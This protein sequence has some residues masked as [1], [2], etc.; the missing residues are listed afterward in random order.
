MGNGLKVFGHNFTNLSDHFVDE[1]QSL[2]R[3]KAIYCDQWIQ[4]LD[5]F[6]HVRIPF[7][8]EDIAEYVRSMKAFDLFLG[9]KYHWARDVEGVPGD[10]AVRADAY[11]GHTRT[12][13][14]IGPPWHCAAA[15]MGRHLEAI[16]CG[17]DE[18]R[19]Q[20]LEEQ[21]AAAFLTTIR[22]AIDALTPA[23]RCFAN[24]ERG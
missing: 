19:R 14:K 11:S 6:R 1:L 7:T 4:V 10:I 16:S 12:G 22:R 21:G 2:E 23:F 5:D 9:A 17:M 24:R 15:F 20:I 3:E 18:S 13:E 8:D